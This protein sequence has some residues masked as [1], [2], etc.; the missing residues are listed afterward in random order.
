MKDMKRV[1][2]EETGQSLDEARKD[3]WES[4][5]KNNPDSVVNE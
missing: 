2:Q 4:F 1:F 3:D 5:K